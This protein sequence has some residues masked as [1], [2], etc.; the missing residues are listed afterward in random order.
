MESTKIICEQDILNNTEN[1]N[2]KLMD[3][4][5]SYCKKQ[6]QKMSTSE[7]MQEYGFRNLT[8]SHLTYILKKYFN[9]KR[10]NDRFLRYDEFD[11][12]VPKTNSLFAPEQASV[13]TMLADVFLKNNNIKILEYLADIPLSEHFHNSYLI[14]VKIGKR[15]NCSM[16]IDADAQFNEFCRNHSS[17][18]KCALTTTA[19]VKFMQAY[20]EEESTLKNI[21]LLDTMSSTEE[22][23]I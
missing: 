13:L 11:Q 6:N 1:A 16:T 7:A 4:Y 12:T 14:P 3:D 22:S 9:L 20:E 8:W 23:G 10:Y 19:L 5:L 21:L 18:D 2:K 15:K 17:I